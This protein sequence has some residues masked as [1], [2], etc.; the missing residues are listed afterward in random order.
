MRTVTRASYMRLQ[1]QALHSEERVNLLAALAAIRPEMVS[2]RRHNRTRLDLAVW[3]MCL[4]HLQV[5]IA[6]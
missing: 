2:V 3:L 6:F 5:G 1:L 4:P